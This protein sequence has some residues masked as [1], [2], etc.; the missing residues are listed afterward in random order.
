MSRGGRV[1]RSVVA[2][3]RL[4]SCRPARRW[5]AK[6]DKAACAE[7]STELNALAGTGIKAE[8]ERGPEWAKANMP[9]ERLQ[10]RAAALEMRRP[11]RI[12]L[13]RSRQ[14]QAG[15]Q[16]ARTSAGDKTP[17]AG[18]PTGPP[19]AATAN[20]RTPTETGDRRLAPAQP[21]P[22]QSTMRRQ[23]GAGASSPPSH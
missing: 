12:S 1:V 22:E 16:T 11:A 21:A 9:P 4:A 14:K 15:R 5:A 18:T 13:R 20:R 6:L 2:A 23:C 7:L 19:N 8:M 3:A 17:P 10:S